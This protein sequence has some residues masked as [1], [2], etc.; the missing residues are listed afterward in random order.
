MLTTV[1]PIASA[2]VVTISKYRNAFPPTRPIFFTSA[3]RAMPSTIVRKMIG[4]ITI[5]TSFT[6]VS[7]SGRICF[8]SAGSSAPST[9]PMATAKST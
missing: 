5:L 9:T 6:N 2:N 7:P 1:R 8:A 3:T 4:P